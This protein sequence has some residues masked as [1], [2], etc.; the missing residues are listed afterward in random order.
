MKKYICE[1]IGTCMLVLL[2]CGSAVLAGELDSSTLATSVYRRHTRSKNFLLP[3]A[4]VELQSLSAS[5]GPIN[6]S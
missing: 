5:N 3:S 1:A 6:I 4:P 2:G